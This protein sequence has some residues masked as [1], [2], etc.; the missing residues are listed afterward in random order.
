MYNSN[1]TW[2][3]WVVPFCGEAATFFRGGSSDESLQPEMLFRSEML[4]TLFVGQSCS[5]TIDYNHWEFQ[6]PKMD[7][8]EESPLT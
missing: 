8:P 5:M 3:G 2:V 4:R 1:V 6:D 7:I